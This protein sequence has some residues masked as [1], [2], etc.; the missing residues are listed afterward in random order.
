MFN[1]YSFIL[2]FLPSVIILYYLLAKINYKLSKLMLILASILFYGLYNM[3]YIPLIIM[4]ILIN[5]YL[6]ILIV[7][8]NK[9]KKLALIITLVLNVGS[10]VY[11]KY[12]NFLIENINVYANTDFTLRKIILPLGISFYTFQQIAYIVDCY[13]MDSVNVYINL[14]DYTFSIL[15]FAKLPQGPIVDYKNIIPQF[16]NH[17]NYKLNWNNLNKG[18][19]FFSFGLLKKVIIADT[20]NKY[21]T[22]GFDLSSSLTFIE[23]WGVAL[24]YTLQLYFDFSGYTDMALGIG[25]FFNIKLPDN[26]DSPYQSNNLIEFWRRWHITLG[27]FLKEY[28]YISLGG[29]RKGKFRKDLNLFITMLICGIWHGAS[30]NFITWGGIHGILLIIN[31]KIKKSVYKIPLVMCRIGTFLCVMLAWVVFRAINFHEALKVY[32][33]MIGINGIKFTHLL[34]FS[35]QGLVI[36]VILFFILMFIPNTKSIYKKYFK[37]NY[38]CLVAI[39]CIF[40]LCL[41]SLKKPTEFLYLQF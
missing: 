34:Y 15:F 38:L 26:F 25:Y 16:K 13:K 14:L 1:T 18:M 23:A 4:S 40:V 39:I 5:Y 29:N 27:D 31:H 41:M 21:V 2:I 11:F 9:Y 33:G 36:S 17:E 19:F 22:P 30:W 7:H 32:K 28:I 12:L 10:L 24:A 3:K 37:P 35:K 20:L 6:G 8:L